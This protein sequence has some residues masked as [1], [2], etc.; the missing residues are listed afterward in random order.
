MM[1]D[2][3]R[4]FGSGF[5]IS[6]SI[7]GTALDQFALYVPEVIQSFQEL[8]RTGNVEFIGETYAHSL[9]SLGR[10]DEFL[11]QVTMHVQKIEK[12]FGVKPATFRNTELIYSDHIG[13]SIADLGFHTMGTEGGKHI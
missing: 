3:I 10:R 9:A 13:E 2:L 5:K 12:L 11:R 4:E 8:A 6:Y 1:L 7:S